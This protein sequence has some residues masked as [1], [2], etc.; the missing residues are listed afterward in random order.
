M[1]SDPV[2]VQLA[3]PVST[4]ATELATRERLRLAQQCT[5]LRAARNH[6]IDSALAEPPAQWKPRGRDSI[7]VRRTVQKASVVLQAVADTAGHIERETVRA[8]RGRKSPAYESAV[9]AL[10]A[11]E[12]TVEEPVPGCTLRRMIVMPLRVH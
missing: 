8:L 4:L 12:P 10:F 11:L 1:E 3:L 5:E 2:R 6:E 9:E 7:E